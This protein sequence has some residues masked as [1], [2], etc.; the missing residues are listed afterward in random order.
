MKTVVLIQF[1]S[2]LY[3]T[4]TSDSDRDYK[5]IYLPSKE[6]IYLGKI[7]KSITQNTKK[8]AKK[9]TSND[10]DIE[11]YSLHYFLKLACEGQTVAIDLLYAPD[12]MILETSDI[13]KKIVEERKRFITKNMQA[14]LG[15]AL[16][17][18][19]KYGIKGS[20]LASAKSVLNFIDNY[21]ANT[22]DIPLN[23]YFKVKEVWNKLPK[24]EHIH[25][26]QIDPN[27]NRIYQV[28]GKK[29]QETASLEY[30]YDVINRFYISYGERARQAERN[31]NIDWKSVSHAIR[32]AYQLK[33]L[34]QK[35][36]IIFP[37]PEANK[38]KDIKAGKL[39]YKTEVAPLLEELIEEVKEFAEKS[40]YPEKTNRK[41]WDNFIMEEVEGSLK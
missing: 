15:Y 3:G 36:F 10:V 24:G 38:I 8:G 19:S 20:R 34:Y 21:Y 27:G 29:V 23:K 33:S 14:F 41:F 28:C 32:A 37:L 7:K 9:N 25:T 16:R 18:A 6:D 5:G 17:Q 1:G 12:D 13:W 31:E 39:N 35:G 4:N 2:F 40:D 11:M 22:Q 30:L 26:D